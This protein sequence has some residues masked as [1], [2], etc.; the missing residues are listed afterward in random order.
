MSYRKFS[1]AGV[2]L[3]LLNLLCFPGFA[4]TDLPQVP[5]CFG[6]QCSG[7]NGYLAIRVDV[8]EGLALDGVVWYNNDASVVFPQILAG[9]GFEDGPGE[10]TSFAVVADSIS[11]SSEAWN[12]TRFDLPVGASLDAL[13]LVFKF[14]EGEFTG[15]GLGG[16]PAIGYYAESSGGEGWVSAEGLDWAALQVAHR[17]AVEPLFVPFEEGMALKQLKPE[18][19][20]QC[21]VPES[22]FLSAGPNPFNPK[23]NIK[24]GLPAAGR[25][26]LS[27]YDLR[28]AKIYTLVSGG[29]EA[30]DHSVIWLGTDTNGQQV[31][32]GI[33]FAHLHTPTKDLTQRLTLVR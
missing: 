4:N 18:A 15:N 26:D 3:C 32:S 27:I 1:F 10:F 13:Y 28:G 2:L 14:P 7:G 29:F 24:F 19:A 20:E 22:A 33:Y 30:G 17:F 16:G 21:N 5:G 23:V 11:G 31:A 9:T 25:I 6:L 12:E 8:P